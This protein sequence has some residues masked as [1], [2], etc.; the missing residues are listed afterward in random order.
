MYVYYVYRHL[1]IY[2]YAYYIHGYLSESELMFWSTNCHCNKQE[3]F[4][5][6]ADSVLCQQIYYLE[7]KLSLSLNFL[8]NFFLE[9]YYKY[10]SADDFA[11]HIDTCFS[12]L[13]C[14]RVQTQ[15]FLA[16][17]HL[18]YLQ[19]MT[20]WQ[21]MLLFLHNRQYCRL[22]NHSKYPYLVNYDN[23]AGFYLNEIPT[24]ADRDS[25]TFGVFGSLLLMAFLLRALV[26]CVKF[27]KQLNI[28]GGFQF[29]VQ[30]S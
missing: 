29:P 17:Y 13:V 5:D 24:Y 27:N 7:M 8:Q 19:H 15:F 21:N 26:F 14:S 28:H 10:S 16:R 23:F 12:G 18:K 2:T 20:C 9:T 25:V 6:L 4:T 22:H 11:T 1:Y 3:K 30:F